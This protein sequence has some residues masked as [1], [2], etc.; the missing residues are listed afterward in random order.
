MP[1]VV[2]FEIA[3]NDPDKAAAFYREVF[4]WNVVKWEGPEEY[5]LVVTG[6]EEEPG[7]DGGIFRPNDIFSGTVNT[8]DVP[9]VDLYIE[10]IKSSGG[11]IVVEKHAIPGVGYSAYARDISGTLFGIHQ[12]EPRAA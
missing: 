9:D 1:R 2:H 3:A 10:K 8:V 12:E 11:E 5:W 6:S 7:I 4:G